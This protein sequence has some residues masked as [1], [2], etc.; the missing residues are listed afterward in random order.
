M[1]LVGFNFFFFFFFPNLSM[2][3]SSD[4]ADSVDAQLHPV[5]TKVLP[6]LQPH[7]PG[8]SRRCQSPS[9]QPSSGQLHKVVITC[10]GEKQTRSARHMNSFAICHYRNWA[11]SA[12][13]TSLAN[14]SLKV[15]CA[16]IICDML[17]KDRL[18]ETAFQSVF[19]KCNPTLS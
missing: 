15:H 10:S 18:S 12:L 19:K 3:H 5:Q 9:A 1:V 7:C 2:T 16:D 11:R 13:Q 6:A 14:T 8:S 17:L 4:K